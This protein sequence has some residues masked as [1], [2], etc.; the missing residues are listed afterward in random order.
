MDSTLLTCPSAYHVSRLPRGSLQWM[1]CQWRF[2]WRHDPSV[3]LALPWVPQLVLEI[4][5]STV[6]FRGKAFRYPTLLKPLHSGI[7]VRM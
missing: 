5:E 4:Y 2:R 6:S 1:N 7:C 3:M